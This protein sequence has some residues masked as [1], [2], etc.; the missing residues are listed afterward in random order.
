MNEIPGNVTPPVS[1]VLRAVPLMLNERSKILT[2]TE[3][4]TTS[5]PNPPRP[6]ALFN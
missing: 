2:S 6:T 3:K 1:R 4:P 5:K